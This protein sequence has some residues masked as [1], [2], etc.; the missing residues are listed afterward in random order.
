MN[1][2]FCFNGKGY[3]VISCLR[4]SVPRDIKIKAYIFILLFYYYLFERAYADLIPFSIE[5]MRIGNY[6][7]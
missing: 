2:Y 4:A 1:N 5:P 6:L 7:S 3:C